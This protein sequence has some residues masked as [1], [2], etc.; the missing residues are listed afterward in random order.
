MSLFTRDF[1]RLKGTAK[2]ALKSR[3]RFGG[4]LE[5]MTIARAWFVEKPR[6]E[7]LRIDQLEIIRSPLSQ[8]V[9]HVRVAVLSFYA[10][11]LDQVLPERDPQDAVFRL[12]TSV[13]EH[14]TVDRCWMPLTYF[15]IWI[16]RLLGLLPDLLHCTVCGEGLQADE[17]YWNHHADGLFCHLHRHPSDG[18]LAPE[19]WR[20]AQRMLR[21]PVSAFAGEMWK[22]GEGADLRKFT[23]QTLERHIEKKLRTAEIL[24]RLSRLKQLD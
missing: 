23:L 4:A 20:M 2:A 12:I 6:Q 15:Q 18:L 3:K 24:A 16:T 5:P 8:S 22:P 9:D 1:G 10:E 14:T 11:A 7:L 13:I 19:S 17:V 21:A